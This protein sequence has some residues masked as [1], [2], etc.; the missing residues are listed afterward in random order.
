MLAVAIHRR[1]HYIGVI[2]R[3]GVH[4]ASL[5]LL[6]LLLLVVHDMRRHAVLVRGGALMLV[7]CDWWKAAAGV[8]CRCHLVGTV[9]LGGCEIAAVWRW[10]T[11]VHEFAHC[12][13]GDL[14]SV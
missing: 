2:R 10:G 14:C 6:L 8:W 9:W 7:V 11:G 12:C 1:C 4:G 3:R 13:A 5:L